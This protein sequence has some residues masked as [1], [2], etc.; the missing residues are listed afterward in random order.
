MTLHCIIKSDAGFIDKQL[1]NKHY[2]GISMFRCEGINLRVFFFVFSHKMLH[3]W[4]GDVTILPGQQTL[5]HDLVMTSGPI[6]CLPPHKT[7]GLVQLLVHLCVPLPHVL[8]Q[9]PHTHELHPPST[10]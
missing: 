4:L 1:N 10:A 9:G 2:L 5:G 7:V 6:H 3:M 8:L